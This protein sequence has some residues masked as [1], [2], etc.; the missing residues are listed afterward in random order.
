MDADV[1]FADDPVVDPVVPLAEIPAD[2]PI[3]DPVIPVE[4]PIEE[5]P[6]DLFGARSFKSVASASL[7]A[8]GVQ[9]YSSDSDSDMA[10]SVAPP[11]FLDV[12]PEPEVEFLPDEPAPIG[13]EPVVAHDPIEAPAVAHL[14]DPLPEPGH[15]DMPDVAPPIIVAPIDLPPIPDA[16]VIDAPIVAPVVP[17]SA[18]VHADHASFASYIDS[19]YADTRN[20]WIE[21]DDDYPPFVLPVT[22][23]VAPI[24]APTDIPLFHP[25]TTDA[26]RTNLPITFLQDIPP[27]RPGE[28]S[29]RQP[30]VSIPPV[31]SS[32]FS[33]TSQF[34][35]IAPPAAPSFIPSSEPFLWTTPPIMPLSDPYHPYHVGYTTEDILTSL[36][37]Q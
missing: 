5:A 4:A 23:P 9:L 19:R 25:H 27:P 24:S 14:P 15:V 26:H 10:M 36:M 28:G 17:V 6:F 13:P 31:L 1:P 30:P 2:V 3:A 37:M 16:P 32:S 35:Y 18:P 8:Q 12:D 21:D 33:F 34:P 29:S 7:H 22:P 11:V 20:G